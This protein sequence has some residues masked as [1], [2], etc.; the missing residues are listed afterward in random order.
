M[1]PLGQALFLVG[2]G[3]VAGAATSAGAI[4]TLISYPALL[5]MGSPRWPRMSRTPLRSWA[6]GLPRVLPQVLNS[7][8]LVGS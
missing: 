7:K 8:E 5:V 2:A 1:S 3:V 4:A 6:P